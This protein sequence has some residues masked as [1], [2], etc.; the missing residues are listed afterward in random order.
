MDLRLCHTV[1]FK[2]FLTK[3]SLHLETNSGVELKVHGVLSLCCFLSTFTLC[4]FNMTFLLVRS[5]EGTFCL[6]KHVCA[7]LLYRYPWKKKHVRRKFFFTLAV[8]HL[9][10]EET[11]FTANFFSFEF[12]WS[13]TTCLTWTESIDAAFYNLNTNSNTFYRSFCCVCESCCVYSESLIFLFLLKTC[14]FK[15]VFKP[16]TCGGL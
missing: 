4:S 16:Q 8:N 6:D 10:K 2:I 11:T 7:V 9:V 5:T 12:V 15:R 3:T 14:S 1:L 13:V